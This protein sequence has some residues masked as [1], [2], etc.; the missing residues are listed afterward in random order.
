[1]RLSF[2]NDVELREKSFS[3]ESQRGFGNAKEDQF[4]WSIHVDSSTFDEKRVICK[5]APGSIRE[6]IGTHSHRVQ[7][8]ESGVGHVERIGGGYNS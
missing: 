4:S 8:D 2:Q 6:I 7:W 1:M 5:P 3:C